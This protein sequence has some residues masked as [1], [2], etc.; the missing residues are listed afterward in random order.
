MI[1]E[2]T[3]VPKTPGEKNICCEI[4][5]FAIGNINNNTP[6]ITQTLL[7]KPG[8]CFRTFNQFNK[9]RKINAEII[10]FLNKVT[11][12][13]TNCYGVKFIDLSI[14]FSSAIGKF[15][16]EKSRHNP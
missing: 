16:E 2:A 6:K 1:K 4:T 11:E 14:D 12:H 3:V 5:R 9:N 13:D 7:L 15:I 8:I 10:R